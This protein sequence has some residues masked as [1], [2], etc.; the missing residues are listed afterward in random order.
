LRRFNLSQADWIEQVRGKRL[1][2]LESFRAYVYL[3][4]AAFP[5]RT[6]VHHR[7]FEQGFVHNLE[8]KMVRFNGRCNGK[9]MMVLDCFNML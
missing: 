7:L 1:R 4:V 2:S 5:A 3:P 9:G 8:A 6:K